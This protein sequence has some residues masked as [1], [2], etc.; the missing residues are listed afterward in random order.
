M[1]AASNS[2]DDA[3]LSEASSN[4]WIMNIQLRIQLEGLRL[5]IAV[6]C[7]SW[8]INSDHQWFQEWKDMEGLYKLQAHGIRWHSI[9]FNGHARP[10][11]NWTGPINL[12]WIK[13]THQS[14]WPRIDKVATPGECPWSS[15]SRFPSHGGRILQTWLSQTFSTYPL[16]WCDGNCAPQRT[17]QKVPGSRNLCQN[18]WPEERSHT[19]TNEKKLLDPCF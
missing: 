10:Q 11:S 18:S 19:S 4:D 12:T 7:R 2:E 3:E 9:A 14:N 15:D 5:D 17:L 1:Q 8:I 16:F 6:I 13:I